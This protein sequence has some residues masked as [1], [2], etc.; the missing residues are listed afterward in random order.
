MRM[1]SSRKVIN[2]DLL[3]KKYS[4]IILI[5][6]LALFSNLVIMFPFLSSPLD[7]EEEDIPRASY[8]QYLD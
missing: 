7:N 1:V 2:V 4:V 5:I 3:D 6:V 8:V